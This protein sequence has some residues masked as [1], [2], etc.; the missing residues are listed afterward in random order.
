MSVEEGAFNAQTFQE[1]IAGLLKSMNRYD[2]DTHPKNSVLVMD[3]CRI[4]KN[5][6]TLEMIRRRYF[7]YACAKQPSL[8]CD[9]WCSLCLFATILTRFQPDW[10]LIF[11]D[12][13]MVQEKLWRSWSMLGREGQPKCKILLDWH[14]IFAGPEEHWWMVH[15]M[16]IYLTGLCTY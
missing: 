7:T 15:K 1:F 12:E 9:K 2:P 8:T 6:E 11:L 13:A 16:W 10:A 4:H 3:N 5:E 14:G